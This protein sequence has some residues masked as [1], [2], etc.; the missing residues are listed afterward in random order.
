[1][2]PYII[3]SFSNNYHLV[4][5]GTNNGKYLYNGNTKKLEDF[6]CDG[7]FRI[8][9][10]QR[11]EQAPARGAG[12]PS[13]TV[14][15]IGDVLSNSA[16]AMEQNKRITGFKID[17]GEVLIKC[18]SIATGREVNDAILANAIK[19]VAPVIQTTPQ[20][21]NTTNRNASFTVQPNASIVQI[22]TAILNA[23]PIKLK[24]ANNTE[25][26]T[27]R[28]I[29]RVR[30]ESIAEFLEKFITSW[31]L[32]RATLYANDGTVQTEPDKRRS[33]GDIFLICRY[34]YPTCT[35]KEV[36]NALYNT[37]PTMITP[38]FRTSIC[39]TIHKRVWYYDEEQENGVMN[40]GGGDEFGKTASWWQTNS[41]A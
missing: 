3:K 33:L 39:S 25:V 15:N 4:T 26:T 41:R 40:S 13:G 10:I 32:K 28:T 18:T 16:V 17:N 22:E 34:Y 36:A 29:S 12:Y 30:R 7:N 31:N 2:Q 9:S 14:F 11:N 23:S 20:Q 8:T 38:G 37:L 19:Y 1:M 5:E 6:I 35:L 21:A 27:G 24:L